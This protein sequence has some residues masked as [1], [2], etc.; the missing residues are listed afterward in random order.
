[1]SA[2]LQR[3]V[4]VTATLAVAVT[5][6]AQ[7]PFSHDPTFSTTITYPISGGGPNVSSLLPL[8]DGSVLISGKFR[9]PGDPG[10]DRLGS[11]LLTN[12]VMDPDFPYSMA[13]GGKM[14]RWQDRFYAVAGHTIYRSFFDGSLDAT[15]I[16]MNSNPEFESVQYGDYHVFSDG[17]LVYGGV[18]DLY[19]NDL[20]YYVPHNFIWF[21]NTGHLDTT[22]V[23]RSG[24]GAIYLIKQ[25]PDGKFICSGPVVEQ[26]GHP[27]G[28]VFRLNADGSLDQ[29]FNAPVIWGE[30]KTCTPLADG[31]MLV[32]GLFKLE[33]APN[34]TIHFIRLMPDGQ[35]DPT[36]NTG[37]EVWK[38]TYGQFTF[39]MHTRLPN[40]MIVAHGAFRKIEGQDRGGMAL[41]DQDGNLLDYYFTGPGVGTFNFQNFT[42][43]S[44][45]GLVEGYDGMWYIHGSYMGFDGNGQQRFV[46]R[47]YPPDLTIGLGEVKEED[48]P[49]LVV[50]PNPA[51]AW[52]SVE[53]PFTHASA[54]R[55]L[56]VQDV[57][58]RPII[59]QR[60][61]IG[62]RQLVL[63]TQ[64]LLP[65]MYLVVLKEGG[66][67][68]AGPV[69][70][71][72]E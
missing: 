65:G 43:G 2:A 21:T 44:V 39:L 7:E 47:L 66:L 52:L 61:G 72:I 71:L 31:R 16:S 67:Q 38:P 70:V 24:S 57:L 26:E 53:L 58:G 18:H 25:M 62:Q 40:G 64:H 13:T 35:V 5:A 11:R 36:F 60:L 14:I 6:F 34:D 48:R 4:F 55:W 54:D 1:M 29:T 56:E 22:K 33:S 3:I 9:F 50:H 30:A 49:V 41:L 51:A 63:D 37:L 15:F 32:S 69:K 12:G 42:Y 17:S 8:E 19:D 59:R 46:T 20:G 68:P 45:Q 27:V 10:Q 28:R 23:H